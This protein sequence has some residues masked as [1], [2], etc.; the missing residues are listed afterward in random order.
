MLLALGLLACATGGHPGALG[1]SLGG[2]AHVFIADDGFARAFY[3]ELTGNGRLTDALEG[4]LLVAVEART[5]RSA[6]VLSMN[7]A[8]PA[9]V[10]LARFHA[11]QT[12][13]YAG[14][15]TE[16]V[17]AFPPGGAAGRSAPPSHVTVVALLDAPPFAA[18]AGPA[19]PG[20]SAADARALV[21]RVAD[22]AE[23]ATRGAPLGLLHPPT[24]DADRAADAGEVVALGPRYGVG[25]R[26]TFVPGSSADTTLITGVAA[27][28]L[29]L[30]NLSW[31]VGPERMRLHG[32]MITS[33]LAAKRRGGQGV[34]YS[35]RGTVSGPG[36]GTL[37]LLDEIADVSARDSRAMAV[38]PA[39][40]RVV[41][42][43]PL[44]LRCP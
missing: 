19:R 24:L 25:F 40:R 18:G 12:C 17:L 2:E 36:G 10:T 14:I 7:G 3:R 16:L 21:R 8:A 4:R 31:V 39:T 20:L 5:A 23:I 6:T 43:Q 28:D 42:A 29:E 37:L 11:P 9:R 27:T 1:W 33:P 13:G 15:V 41:A 38:D 26:A 35:V 44:A 32:G 34:R 30:R 22:R